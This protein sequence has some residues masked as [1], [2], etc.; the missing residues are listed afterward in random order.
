MHLIIAWVQY[1]SKFSCLQLVPFLFR[2]KQSGWWKKLQNVCDQ[3]CCFVI[4]YKENSDG[5]WGWQTCR[6]LSIVFQEKH[7]WYW[8]L[9]RWRIL[10]ILNI[11]VSEEWFG[12][13]SIQS[14]IPIALCFV[15]TKSSTVQS[16][17]LNSSSEKIVGIVQYWRRQWHKLRCKTLY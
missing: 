8:I 7:G 5:E 9:K 2:N 3:I 14:V 17:C 1:C 16:I 11:T 4:N 12:S 15:D 6:I 13:Y 10:I